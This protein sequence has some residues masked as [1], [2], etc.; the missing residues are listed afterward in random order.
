MFAQDT[1]VS[2]GFVLSRELVTVK[3]AGILKLLKTHL[4]VL[5]NLVTLGFIIGLNLIT[6]NLSLEILI[7]I[8]LQFKSMFINIIKDNTHM[9]ILFISL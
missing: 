2:T 4:T 7:Y 9:I 8:K 5:I 3:Q 6:T 1:F